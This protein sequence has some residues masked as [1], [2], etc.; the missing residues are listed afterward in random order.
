M[1]YASCGR[2]R[3]SRGRH[4]ST[5]RRRA[6]SIALSSPR[7]GRPADRMLHVDRSGESREA[8]GQDHRNSRRAIQ[9]SRGASRRA[10]RPDHR[11][12][13]PE[14]DPRPARRSTQSVSRRSRLHL[15]RAT[16]HAILDARAAVHGLRRRRR[17]DR[18]RRP[19]GSGG[20]REATRR[21]AC[22]LEAAVGRRSRRLRHRR[23]R[24]G[25]SSTSSARSRSRSS[26]CSACRTA[27]VSP[28]GDTAVAVVVSR[29]CSRLG[30]PSRRS[31]R[32]G[33]D[34]HRPRFARPPA[35]RLRDRSG[36]RPRVSRST[37]SV[38]GCAG[39]CESNAC[40][41]NRAGHAAVFDQGHRAQLDRRH[42][43]CA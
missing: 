40:R 21:C 3:G 8:G 14:L 6:R 29:G 43:R 39:A 22:V 10:A 16:R 36:V 31:L 7:G 28:R 20:D 23:D 24:L 30:A 33:R 19:G 41:G 13:G 9:E 42:L 32:R 25:S 26:I 5:C 1:Q 37:Y 18:A 34:R 15:V 38:D 2:F 11:R 12:S 17:G 4:S 35:R 27:R